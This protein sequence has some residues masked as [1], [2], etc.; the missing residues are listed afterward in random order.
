M[1]KSTINNPKPEEKIMEIPAGTETKQVTIA[2]VTV[3]V[4]LPFSEGHVLSANEAAVLNQ[5]FGENIRNNNASAFRK[6]IEESGGKPD[7]SLL[8]TTIDTYILDY[9]FGVRRGGG[10][11]GSRDPVTT[12]AMKIARELL[13]NS[14]KAKGIKVSEVGAEQLNKLAAEAIEKHPQI[15]EQAEVSV[16]ARQAAVESIE[17]TL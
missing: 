16:A 1:S 6:V 8:Q 7:V 3:A 5:T 4:P 17:L 10:G 15:R 9:E 11:G 12:E 14:L 13:R 2:G